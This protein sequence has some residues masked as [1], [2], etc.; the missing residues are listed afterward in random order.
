MAL[1]ALAALGLLALGL[2][3]CAL[4]EE[5]VKSVLECALTVLGWLSLHILLLLL[6]RVE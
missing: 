1:L 2:L 6:L 5:R 3:V 4:G